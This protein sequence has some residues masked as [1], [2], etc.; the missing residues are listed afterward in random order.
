MFRMHEIIGG[1]CVLAVSEKA[2]L[3]KST[4]PDA[5]EPYVCWLIDAD[6][7]GVHTGKYFVEQ[8]DAEWCFAARS[9]EWFE[10]NVNINMIE[11]KPD[12]STDDTKQIELMEASIRK[13]RAAVHEFAIDINKLNQSAEERNNAPQP[14]SE[15]LFNP[16][17]TSHNGKVFKDGIH[18]MVGDENVTYAPKNDLEKYVGEMVYAM[19]DV[20]NLGKVEVYK[21][22]ADEYL[23]DWFIDVGTGFL[24][25][26]LGGRGHRTRNRSFAEL[27]DDIKERF[28]FAETTSEAQRPEPFKD[29]IEKFGVPS[30]VVIDDGSSFHEFD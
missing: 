7:N 29:F 14:E 10:D 1:H 5:P 30:K 9:F 27:R 12:Y 18:L 21:A 15:E 2:V 16:V 13:A 26:D 22:N 25:K 4:A 28:N 19:V 24:V 3:A 17:R 23:G 20:S 11:D 6:R 8:M